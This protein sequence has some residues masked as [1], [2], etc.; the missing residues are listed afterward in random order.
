MTKLEIESDKMSSSALLDMVTAGW[1]Q[2]P[3]Y[4]NIK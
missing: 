2:T 4:I 1:N 3:E